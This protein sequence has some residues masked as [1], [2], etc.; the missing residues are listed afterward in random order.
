MANLAFNLKPQ[1]IAPSTL[2][3]ILWIKPTKIRPLQENGMAAISKTHRVQKCIGEVNQ[4]QLYK[5]CLRQSYSTSLDSSFDKLK[6]N[7][8]TLRRCSLGI[9]SD[10]F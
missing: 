1:V 6:Q 8:Y 10:R 7:I 3:T 4:Q 5:H 2:I 9:L